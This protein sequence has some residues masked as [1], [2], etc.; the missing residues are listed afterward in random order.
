[1]PAG[2]PGGRGWSQSPTAFRPAPAWRVQHTLCPSCPENPGGWPT[3]NPVTT[4]LGQI[5]DLGAPTREWPMASHPQE[6]KRHRE[7]AGQVVTGPGT[8]RPVEPR[9]AL[10]PGW[11]EH[12][13]QRSQGQLEHWVSQEPGQSS[14]QGAEARRPPSHDQALPRGRGASERAL[15]GPLKR[16]HLT[17]PCTL[18]P[19]AA[20]REL[21]GSGGCLGVGWSLD[22]I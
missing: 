20:D 16:P 15:A 10:A 19:W 4:V 8:E 1:M 22:H 5:P 9:L 12:W 6:L 7:E 3:W 2:R 13:Q 18:G 14:L 21:P 11:Q 17:E